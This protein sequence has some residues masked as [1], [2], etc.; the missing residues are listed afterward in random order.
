LVELSQTITDL[1]NP[2]GCLILS[3]ILCEQAESV[4]NAYENSF[5]LTEPTIQD[6]WCRL[7]GIKS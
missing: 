4:K 2:K 1:V 7:D 3:G 5:I 6:D